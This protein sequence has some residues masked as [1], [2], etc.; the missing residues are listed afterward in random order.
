MRNG[1]RLGHRVGLVI[2][3]IGLMLPSFG[4]AAAGPAAAALERLK[5]GNAR[6]VANASTEQPIATAR[7]TE[8]SKGQTPYAVVLSCSD[9][10]VPPEIVFNTGLGELF[11]VR[12]AGQVT[13]KSILASVEYGAEHLHAPLLVVMGHESCGAVKATMEATS[14]MG[15]NLDYLV[16]SIRP[17]VERAKLTKEQDALRA[18]VFANVEQVI[19][20]TLKQSTI[21]HHLVET[22]AL[23]VVGAYY[24]LVS[25]RVVFSKPVHVEATTTAAHEAS[26]PAPSPAKTGAEQTARPAPKQEAPMRTPAS[27]AIAPIVIWDELPAVTAPAPTGGRDGMAAP[28]RPVPPTA[29]VPAAPAAPTTGRGTQAAANGPRAIERRLAEGRESECS[30]PWPRRG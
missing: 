14:S 3:G 17:A 23:Q 30:V 18:A 5:A 28:P 10:R 20:D 25:G 4:S 6:F 2:I 24:E 9:S 8:L 1:T 7:R 13:D 15:P 26:E 21:L 19:G 27:S 29:T 22:N 12:A 16:K 11:V